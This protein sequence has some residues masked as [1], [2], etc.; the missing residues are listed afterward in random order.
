VA[1]TQKADGTQLTLVE[2]GLH[3]APSLDE[4]HV[5]VRAVTDDGKELIL[6]PRSSHYLLLT[7]AR[8]RIQDARNGLPLDEQG[9]IYASDF[10]D[11]LQYTAERV[12]LE[13]FRARSLLAK[14]GFADS[15]HLIER[16]PSTRQ[17]RIGVARLHVMRG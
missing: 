8:A 11:M 2:I 6:P 9:W 10:A 1:T 3:F 15:A 7:L 14:L 5:D 12:N 13:I 16:R 4:E 17:L